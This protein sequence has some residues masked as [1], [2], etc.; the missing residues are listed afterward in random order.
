MV[1]GAA[2]A[3]TLPLLARQESRPAPGEHPA[4]VLIDRTFAP[5]EFTLSFTLGEEG[6]SRLR[7]LLDEGEGPAS[8]GERC[9]LA[10]DF[11][12]FEGTRF[13]WSRATREQAL[14]GA[15]ITHVPEPK[16][17]AYEMRF[18]FPA[19]RGLEVSL[20][21]GSVV[22][23]ART[24][25]AGTL[26]I[27]IETEGSVHGLSP[28]APAPAGDAS[29]A[30]ALR[31]LGPAADGEGEEDREDDGEEPAPGGRSD[32]RWSRVRLAARDAP[33]ILAVRRV[34]ESAA[35]EGAIERVLLELA[36]EWEVPALVVN[37]AGEGR[38]RAVLLVAGGALGKSHPSALRRAAAH[39][40]A[41]AVV[42]AI[43]LLGAG[44][45]RQLQ[46]HDPLFTP[47][48]ELVGRPAADFAAD[49]VA[50][51]FAWIS[52]LPGVDS[53]AVGLLVDG[54]AEAALAQAGA[55][56]GRDDEAEL[57]P[58]APS[59]ELARA[60]VLGEEQVR[61]RY[62]SRLLGELHT[63]RE[64]LPAP[65]RS[66]PLRE[67]A[68]ALPATAGGATRPP[69]WWNRVAGARFGPLPRGSAPAA[70]ARVIACASDFGRF[71]ALHAA[72]RALPPD[73]GSWYVALPDRPGRDV[74]ADADRDL[75]ARGGALKD[76]IDA[77]LAELGAR[78]LELFGEGSSAVALLHVAAL[79]GFEVGSV[80]ASRA[81]PG[82]ELLLQRPHDAPRAAASLGLLTQGMPRE[83]FVRGALARY[84]LEDLVLELRR[85][86]VAVDWRD[87]VDALRRPLTRHDRLSM[88]PRVRHAER[89]P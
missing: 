26:T 46:P 7:V 28:G 1:A 77:V 3:A 52:Q 73:D 43:D 13:T 48:L 64:E 2:L 88:W 41:G 50:Q 68:G 24:P 31:L 44:E 51:L 14:E 30:R 22:L 42:V 32:A 38:R 15:R 55:L 54:E 57:E 63:L 74:A 33:S 8:R 17:L 12:P 58:A 81:L 59:D 86:G 29:L 71:A 78:K 60:A 85:R 56:A 10:L 87:P 25:G 72:A 75:A 20:A 89:R 19:G 80:T 18:A 61:T 35:P 62:D 66:V 69:L 82:F 5:V 70:G 83:L 4:P 21:D 79:S 53:N 27:S 16:G 40:R 37:P 36:E 45:R 6:R 34:D 49:E 39:A 47:E 9:V 23:A 76:S 67:R 84:D 65:D 11:D